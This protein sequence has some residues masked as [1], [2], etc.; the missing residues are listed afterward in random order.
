[1]AQL[2][3]G[4]LP[5]VY[6]NLMRKRRNVKT[7]LILLNSV[8][9]GMADIVAQYKQLSFK[10]IGIRNMVGASNKNLFNLRLNRQSRLTNI[11]LVYRNLAIMNNFEAQLFCSAVKNIAA[12]FA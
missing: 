8:V 4:Q 2:R 7:Y 9:N 11:G 6:N 10:L 1:M 3:T 5:F 12:L